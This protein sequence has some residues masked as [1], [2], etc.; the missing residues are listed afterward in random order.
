MTITTLRPN[1][2]V[3]SNAPFSVNGASTRWQA[4]SDNSDSSFVVGTVQQGY[5]RVSLGNLSALSAG[6][7]IKSLTVRQRNSHSVAGGGTETMHNTIYDDSNTS[8]GTVG[9]SYFT[10]GT[11]TI[12]TFAGNP[13]YSAPGGRAWSAG[14][15]NLI[16]LQTSYFLANDGSGNFGRVYELYIDVDINQQPIVSGTPTVVTV[17]NNAQPTVKWV[18]EDD[19]GDPQTAWQVKIFDSS[20]YGSANFDPDTSIPAWDSNQ[21]SGANTSAIVGATTQAYLLNG[22]TYKAYVKLAQSW[23]GPQG[24][25]WWSDWKPS[26]TFSVT[27][28]VPYTPTITASL[29][30]DKHT[31]QALL[32]T[33]ATVNLL[34][35]DNASFESTVGS[36]TADSNMSAPARSTVNP[37]DGLADMLLNSTAAGTMV[38]RCSLVG[39]TPTVHPGT[40]YTVLA[41]FRSLVSAR[42]CAVGVRWLN[43]SNGTISTQFG[44]T[45][46]DGTGGYI[47][48]SFT[49]VAPALSVTALVVI[50]V[51][52]TGAANEQHRVDQVSLAVGSSTSWTPGGYTGMQ[53]VIIERG[54]FLDNQ[55]GPADNWAHI[56]IA[57]GGSLTHNVNDGF[58][59]PAG[60]SFTWQYCNLS[61]STGGTPPGMLRWFTQTAATSNM[62]IAGSVNSDTTQWRFPVVA[63]QIHTLSMWAWTESGTFTTTPRILWKDSS[64]TTTTTSV[65]SP[66]TLTTTPQRIVFSVAAP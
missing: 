5:F 4:V 22:V 29:L 38:A 50:E 59:P 36:W 31:Y 32:T 56:Q 61:L 37:L 28:T 27:Y 65:G 3:L 33:T 20:T 13:A 1:G 25:L 18:Y 43:A 35:S 57:S 62:G 41:S 53:D 15:V 24:N 46:T 48:A 17:A 30:Q 16:G 42:S 51:L 26:G 10:R 60:D 6:Q 7:R 66:V 40:T 55:R 58:N 64:E 9:S 12:T 47:Q 8:L 34:T 2:D 14:I 45:V 23:P 54:E 39:D 52:S 63:G 19:D 11:Q 49:G 21:N 44:S